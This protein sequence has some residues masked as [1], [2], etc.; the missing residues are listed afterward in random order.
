MLRNPFAVAEV[1]GWVLALQ[2]AMKE[3][4]IDETA[5]EYIAEQSGENVRTLLEGDTVLNIKLSDQT[6]DDDY[7]DNAIRD[8][9]RPEPKG[10]VE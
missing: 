1:N 7:V 3:G 2:Q 8:H 10:Y 4:L 9:Y 6:E 5:A